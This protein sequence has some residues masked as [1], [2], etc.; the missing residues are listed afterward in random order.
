MDWNSAVKTALH[1][2]RMKQ[3]IAYARRVMF[4]LVYADEP[5]YDTE[6]NI[7]YLRDDVGDFI[8]EYETIGETEQ[9]N[10][11]RDI[12][13]DFGEDFHDKMDWRAKV[14]EFFRDELDFFTKLINK[15]ERFLG[16]YVPPK[17]EPVQLHFMF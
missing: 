1:N 8:L 2:A 7:E 6:E 4:L 16:V 17:T 5:S 9:A 15:Y 12:Y 14:H 3:K 13:D 11:L 10:Q